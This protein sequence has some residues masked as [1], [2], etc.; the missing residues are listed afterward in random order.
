LNSTR[1]EI[2]E[3][4]WR[5]IKTCLDPQ[6]AATIAEP[7][8]YRL[9]D[10][11]EFGRLPSDPSR[12]A[13]LPVRN[14]APYHITG[15][16]GFD[17]RPGVL[18]G[19]GSP[20]YEVANKRWLLVGNYVKTY[21]R[22]ATMEQSNESARHAVRAI[23]DKIL[24]SDPARKI[25][26]GAADGSENLPRFYDPEDHELDDL[27]FLRRVDDLLYEDGLPH[28]VEIVKLRQSML[29]WMPSES[30]EHPITRLADVLGA[31]QATGAGRL[32][33]FVAAVG[34]GRPS[35]PGVGGET[36]RRRR[37]AIGGQDDQGGVLERHRR[38]YRWARQRD[39]RTPSRLRGVRLRGPQRFADGWR[40]AAAVDQ[41]R[42]GAAR[43]RSGTGTQGGRRGNRRAANGVQDVERPTSV[44][45]ADR[46]ASPPVRR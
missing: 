46:T 10:Y 39:R 33:T 6:S 20:F 23:I 12:S 42:Q 45:N 7:L 41:R 9:D 25:Y 28:M 30:G 26:R 17:K 16:A 19:E 27:S 38:G 24:R 36:D 35:G 40:S 29:E 32:R 15:V 3:T 5:Q 22:I 4:A 37:A 14:R 43:A 21:T 18:P 34:Q 13:D 44:G 2:A 8:W 11:I 31:V 1:Q